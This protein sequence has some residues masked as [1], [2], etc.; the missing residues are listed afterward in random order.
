[1]NYY[2]Y[3]P[4]S[5]SIRAELKKGS[6]QFGYDI[7]GQPWQRTWMDFLTQGRLITDISTPLVFLENNWL[8]TPVCLLPESDAL[9]KQLLD[10]NFE[11]Q[12]KALRPFDEIFSIA[13]PK[14][15]KFNGQKIQGLFVSYL[16]PDRKNEIVKMF[17]HDHGTKA[18]LNHTEKADP[19]LTIC[20]SDPNGHGKI[21]LNID[22]WKLE[23]VLEAKTIE[24]YHALTGISDGSFIFYDLSKQEQEQQ[25]QFEILK[26]VI[27]FI[28]YT[29]VHENAIEYTK[30][31]KMPSSDKHTSN[32]IINKVKQFKPEGSVKPHYRNLRNERYY[33]NQWM[34]WAPG[35]RWVPV[36]M[37]T[38]VVKNEK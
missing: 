5:F 33:R 20:Y 27:A 26:F 21:V 17:N 29:S 14:E 24:E 22:L 32:V 3:N 8:K 35:S 37:E 30:S 12:I 23:W 36:N 6:K 16:T 34:D 4:V 15:T 19:Q 25:T 2:L 13:L 18:Q 11:G 28:V 10:T 38:V 31:I 9:I 1:M 7:S